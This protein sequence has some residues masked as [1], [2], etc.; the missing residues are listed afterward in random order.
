[1]PVPGSIKPTHKA[2][3]AYYETLA[4]YADQKVKHEGATETGFQRLLTDT[5]RS[6]GWMLVPKLTVKRGGKSVIPD[7]TVRDAYS[8]HRGY[9]EA[10]DSDDDLAAEI[11]KKIAKGY[12]LTNII[13]EDTQRAVLYQNGQEALKADLTAPQALADLLNAFFSHTEPGKGVN[14]VFDLRSDDVLPGEVVLVENGA[15][16][17]LGEKVLNQHLIDCLATDVWVEGGLAEGKK[18]LK[19]GLE[20]GVRLV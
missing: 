12:P 5:A 19:S 3:K 17:P 20:C 4:A 14:D 2:I 11:R 8:L 18:L 13:F 15:N 7:G 1:M 6:H 10:K 16:E 9:W